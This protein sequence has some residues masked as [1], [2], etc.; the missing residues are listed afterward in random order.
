[1]IYLRVLL[2]DILTTVLVQGLSKWG[3]RSM[4]S[5]MKKKT[6]NALLPSL[7]ATN[8]AASE[9]MTCT[10]K[11]LS[12]CPQ[13][14]LED[15]VKQANKTG[16]G[17]IHDFPLSQKREVEN[18][19]VKEKAV[20]SKKTIIQ[21]ILVFFLISISST[22]VFAEYSSYHES[23]TGEVAC[24]G[25]YSSYNESRTGEVCAGGQYSSYHESRTGE[26]ACGG[27]YSSYHE[28]RTGEVCA[29]G[30]YS[31]YHESRTGEVACG[32]QYSSYHE[33]RTGK[34]CAGG[35]YKER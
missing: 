35:D 21:S 4:I 30:Q 18:S 29:G 7:E 6:D 31:S 25:Q 11:R 13:A 16:L 5:E 10:S 9:K 20:V 32:G 33:S 17:F 24:G 8:T 1:M 3:N 19:Q 23:R 2:L 22:S 27:Q 12:A 26:V 15:D 28:S 34:V 14:R